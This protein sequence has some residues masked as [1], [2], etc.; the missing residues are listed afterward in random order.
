MRLFGFDITRQKEKAYSPVDYR[1]G[2]Y[3]FVR[4][5]NT[6]D[7]QR[8]II[9]DRSTVLAYDAVFAC[10]TLIASDI[11]KLRIKLVER[12]GDG[13]WTE[14]SNPAYSPV[15]RKPNHY[16]TRIQF[17]ESW[18]L[19]KLSRGNTY[20]LKQRDQRGVVIRLYVLD[21]CRV[22][23]LVADNGDVFYELS[24]DDLSRLPEEVAVPAREIIHDRFNCLFH[25]LCGVSP[26]YAANLPSMQGS[27]IQ[28]NST[29]F[30]EN[31]SLPGGVLT[32][33]G[34]I[35]PANAQRLKAAFEEN[36]TGEN[37]GRVAVLGDGL[38]FE[39]LH[40]TA[41]DSQMI[42]QL[43]LTAGQ[44]CSAFHVPPY[45]IGIPPMPAYN[46][47]QS[48]NVEYYSQCLQRLIEDVE[49]LLDEGL[50]TGLDLGTELDLDGLLRM[51]AMTQ[52]TTLEHGIK[53]IMSPNEA[54]RKLDL[55]PVPGGDTPYMQEQNFSLEALS[56]RDAKPDPFET[57][58]EPAAATPPATPAVDTQERTAADF[59]ERFSTLV[60]LKLLERYS[61]AC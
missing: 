38:K 51:D 58:P 2:W 49:L 53:G 54:R 52:F 31:R 36:F 8:N 39:N 26:L 7:W 21:P 40:I 45:K 29:L 5:A 60:R 48:L 3:P 1:G 25:P 20:L 10:M 55:K 17:L 12:D 18:I 50:D 9:V 37:A 23:P 46:N 44:V 32:A 16:Q 43:K 47:I 6:G 30:F 33:P 35:D 61:Y 11:A 4:E 56:K 28:T 57:T 27:R 14:T 42:E 13:I 24:V 22:K 34:H 15:L 41:E 59:T 19:S